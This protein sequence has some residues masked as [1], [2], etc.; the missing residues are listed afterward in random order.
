MKDLPKIDSLLITN[1]QLDEILK[2]LKSLK[3]ELDA[4]N[5]ELDA[6]E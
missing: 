1:P 5:K 4:L 6:K 3:S 2:Q